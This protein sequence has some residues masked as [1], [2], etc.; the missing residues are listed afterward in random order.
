MPA[1]GTLGLGHGNLNSP[2]TGPE[3]LE[4]VVAI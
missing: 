3:R 1:D 2:V 4:L